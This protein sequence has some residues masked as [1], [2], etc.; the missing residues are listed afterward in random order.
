[1]EASVEQIPQFGEVQFTIQI[2]GHIHYSA[3]AARRLVGR[4]VAGEIAY[5]LRSGEPTLVVKERIV[6]RVPVELALPG[7]GVV[8]TVGQIDVDVE[9]GEL[10]I[11][12]E[13]THQIQENA[14]QKAAYY[15]TIA[16]TTP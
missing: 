15:S 11:T 12:P 5:L 16:S 14:E 13:L 1:M 2:S 7:H 10:A 3:E 6:W 4:Y 9:T 8:G